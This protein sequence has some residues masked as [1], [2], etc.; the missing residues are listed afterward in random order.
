M[1]TNS[2]A[3]PILNKNIFRVIAMKY[4]AILYDIDGT[5]LDTFDMN[6]YPLMQI[7]REELGQECTLEQL[8]PFY[9]QPGLKTMTDLGIRDVDGVYARWVAYVNAYE[10][11]AVPYP[12]MED[13]LGRIRAA[14]IRQAVVSSK[15]HRQYEID[16]GRYHMD[17]FMETAVLAEDTEKHK[18][19]PAPIL[20][21]LRRMEL[22][23]EDVIYIGDALSDL[24]AARNAGVDFGLAGWG[25]VLTDCYPG[26]YRFETTEEFCR[27]VTE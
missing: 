18:P 2:P 12:G 6:M 25:S 3:D 4:K 21:C 19:D 22:Q 13:A 20:E 1:L 7:I 15:M 5:L 9:A 24:Q 14:G 16:M 10:K 27:F 23:P 11:G 26:T 17:A 8:R